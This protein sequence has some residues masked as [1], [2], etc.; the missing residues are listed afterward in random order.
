[1]VVPCMYCLTFRGLVSA[2]QT[3]A[4]GASIVTLLIAS[5]PLDTW[6]LRARTRCPDGG[7]LPVHPNRRHRGEPNRAKWVDDQGPASVRVAR[8][9]LIPA[10]R[11]HRVDS[12]LGVG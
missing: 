8:P 7:P 10:R 4:L 11:S 2:S 1:M 3:L 9:P 6:Y 5:N 12:R